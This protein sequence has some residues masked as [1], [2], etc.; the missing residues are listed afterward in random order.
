MAERRVQQQKGAPVWMYRFDFETDVF[1]GALGA[2]HALDVPYVFGNPDLPLTGTSAGRHELADIVCEAW[3]TF[4]RHGDPRTGALV[5]WA[6]YEMDRRST[7]ILDLPPRVVD[8]PDADE[9]RAWGDLL[10]IGV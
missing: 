5:D 3:A 7:M 4:A 10:P 6:P 8:D 2:P 1:E 9:R